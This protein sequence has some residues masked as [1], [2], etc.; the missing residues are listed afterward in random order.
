MLFTTSK[1][2]HKM[3]RWFTNSADAEKY[4][5]GLYRFENRDCYVKEIS[6]NRFEVY[7]I[8]INY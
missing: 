3:L 4:S 5:D 8:Q 6:S 1:N 7:E 2:K